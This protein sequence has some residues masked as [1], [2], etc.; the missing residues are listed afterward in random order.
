MTAPIPRDIPDIPAIPGVPGLLPA[1]VPA[2]AV[3]P[4]VRRPVTATLRL[5]TALTAA[6]AVTLAFLHGDPLTVLSLF[7]VQSTI[8]LTLVLALSARRSWTARRPLPA[9]LT[10]ATVLYVTI[11]ALVHHL[12]PT[13]T[14]TLTEP[15]SWQSTLA[16]HLIH[17]A[18]P[19]AALLDWLLLTPPARL[20]LRKASAWLLYPLAYLAF[21]V[22]RGEL[23]PVPSAD[24]YLYPFLDI[25]AHG[26]KSTLGNALLLGLACYALAVL[27]VALDHLRPNPIRSHAKTGFRLQPPVG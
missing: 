9:P 2:S 23:L 24:R 17:T 4:P 10:G 25:A 18:L 7:A 6:A 20:H 14:P 1:P 11:G 16:G 12:L 27:L 13:T 3:I 19:L 26:Y 21:T 5:L 15:A 22:V 8:L